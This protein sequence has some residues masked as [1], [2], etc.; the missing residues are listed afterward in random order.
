MWDI[1]SPLIANT[2]AV[3]LTGLIGWA[4]TALQR[5]FNIEIEASYRESLHRAVMTGVNAALARVG[6][7][8][9]PLPPTMKV[10]VIDEAIE[11]T[12]KSVPDAIRH[13]DVS[14]EVL[15]SLA[16]S[17]LNL[18]DTQQRLPATQL[19]EPAPDPMRQPV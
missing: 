9:E 8:V 18:I 7:L 4:A 13:L 6:G 15:G 11:Y 3:I 1:I 12:K 5:K 17:K 14:P 10:Q 16:T 19:P 2:L